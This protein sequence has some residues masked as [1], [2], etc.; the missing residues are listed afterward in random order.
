MPLTSNFPSWSL[1][2]KKQFLKC[3]LLLI[4]APSR[5]THIAVLW[6][7]GATSN[8]PVARPTTQ[9][10]LSTSP[11]VI[12]AVQELA[13]G[14]TDAE[15]A[16]LLNQRGLV[17]GKGFPFT[18]N[19]VTWIRWKF[20]INKPVVGPATGIRALDGYYSTSAL[21]Q[22]LGVGI[23]TIHYWREKGVLEAFQQTPRGTWWHRVTPSALETLRQKIRRV[24]VNSD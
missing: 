16:Q 19:A 7:T 14:R 23:H 6:H 10:K 15:I 9:E 12:E 13:V 20:E 5:R 2:P 24:R 8:F 4:H 1:F 17:T 18:K 22:K 21:A 11:D 3:Y